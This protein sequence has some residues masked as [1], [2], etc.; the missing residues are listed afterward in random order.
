M[1]QFRTSTYLCDEVKVVPCPAFAESISEGDL[2]W[3]KAVGDSVAVDE[4]LCEIET[5]KT[6]V[7]VPSPVAG[8]VE[9]LL[10]EDGATVS[11]GTELVKIL[12]GAEG[13][14]GA[15]EPEAKKEDA[16][17]PKADSAA[18]AA[19]GAAAGAAAASASIPKDPPPTPKTESKPVATKKT[20]E[21][22]SRPA[23]A[24]VSSSGAAPIIKLPPADPTKE[25]VGTRSEHRVKM[26]RMR[27]KIS[28]RLKDA[29]NTNAMLTTF[30]EI[31]MSNIM[32]LRKDSQ[33]A[34]VKRHGIKLGFM[35]AFIK[36]SAHAL[37]SQPTVNAVIDGNEIV[38]RD[39]VDISVAVATPKVLVFVVIQ[40]SILIF[41]LLGLGRASL[42]KCA[43]HELC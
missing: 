25:I 20:S 42:A 5:D 34:F 7:P 26:N 13:A 14:S 27:L 1:R 12:V 39:F 15:K 41:G 17:A 31:D 8:R 33:D 36:A 16:A 6:S 3:E 24:A 43:R 22:P 18:S 35:S 21:I 23:P 30:N 28:Q 10:V 29:Q 9:A 2:R 32:Q 40:V 38:Y 4:V 37:Q 19:A 11:P